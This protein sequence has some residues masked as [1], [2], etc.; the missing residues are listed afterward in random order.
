[1]ARSRSPR[2][3]R[4][5]A[6]LRLLVAIVASLAVAIAPAV[7]QSASILRDS[8]TEAY[9]YDIS[10]PLI[11][12]AGLDPRN[13]RVMLVGDME[14]NAFVAGGQVVYIN[15]G[16]IKAADNTNQLQGVIAHELGHVAGG[17]AINT[18]GG[19]EA[20]GISVLSLLLA[21]A[22]A[23]AGGGEAA[24]G[25]LAAGQQ[26]AMGKYLA[27]SRTQEASADAA[28]STYMTKAHISGKG[29]LDF[30][31]KLEQEEFRLASTYEP[32]DPFAMTH[33]MSAD[34][35]NNLEQGYKASPWWTAKTNPALDSRF[36]RI[37]AKLIG[38]VED[39]DLVLRMF[40]ESDHSVP[41]M[42]ARAYAWHRKAYPEKAIAESD[43]L[44]ATAPHDPYFLELKGQILLESGKVK[45]A[46]PVLREAVER[47]PNQPLIAALFGHALIETE[48]PKN[49]AEAKG[50]LK[51]AIA[52]DDDNPF[53]WYQLGIVYDRE[54]DQARAALATA[55]RYNL[56]GQAQL[57]LAN[58]K[59]AMAG[60][61]AGTPDWIRA[62]D[63]A[64]VSQ[65]AVS[66]KKKG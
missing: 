13:V 44:V 3:T 10:K 12:A 14:I 33:P 9:F 8:E 61:K 28:S 31:R 17:H 4:R 59:L 62:Q 29:Q 51:A 24:M 23:A 46:V 54:G 40:P 11:E 1:M 60:L 47:A 2:S 19:K 50:I 37:R 49:F 16:L 42:Y 5:S 34:R 36:A 56:E 58:A 57:A 64:L 43:R 53:A 21:G 25:V 32:T 35:I 55:E 26:A 20:T 45:E 41:A 30:F 48:D 39:P 18:A 63:I 6:P 66:K 27:F 15:A 7:A 52:R 38:Y 22:A 65:N